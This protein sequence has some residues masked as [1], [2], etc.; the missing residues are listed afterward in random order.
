MGFPRLH[1][2]GAIEARPFSIRPHALRE[3][4]ESKGIAAQLEFDYGLQVI[5]LSGSRVLECKDRRLAWLPD[6]L[7]NGT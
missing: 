1:S 3:L 7:E 2:G 6:T 5:W 4:I